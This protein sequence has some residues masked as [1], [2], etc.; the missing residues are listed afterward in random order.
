VYDVVR[1]SCATLEDETMK[2]VSWNIRCIQGAGQ[3]FDR[4]IHAVARHE[5]K[6]YRG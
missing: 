4:I 5:V 1:Q 6:T 2:I 3:E